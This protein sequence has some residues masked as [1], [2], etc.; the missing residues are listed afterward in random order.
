MSNTT[1]LLRTDPRY[2]GKLI[3][4]LSVAFV[5]M[6]TVTLSQSKCVVF[7]LQHQNLKPIK[8]RNNTSMSRLTP[9]YFNSHNHNFVWNKYKIGWHG[10][11]K[12]ILLMLLN[13]QTVAFQS[14]VRYKIGWHGS[15]KRMK[16]MP[17]NTHIIAFQSY[18]VC[19][20]FN[21]KHSHTKNLLIDALGLH[22]QQ[23]DTHMTIVSRWCESKI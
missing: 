19:N 20:N 14:Y 8:K 16:L 7:W 10:R 18:E 1:K 9:T 17:L 5:P 11:R 4:I 21:S 12:K 6:L 23:H 2:K 22:L 3:V 13:T 15:L